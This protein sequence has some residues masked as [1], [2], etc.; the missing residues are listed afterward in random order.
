MKIINSLNQQGPIER[1]IVAALELFKGF[2]TVDHTLW[3]IENM[4]LEYTNKES[5]ITQVDFVHCA[6]LNH[7]SEAY[8]R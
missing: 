5:G 7:S 8:V 4:F 1:T 6:D 2:D 3:V